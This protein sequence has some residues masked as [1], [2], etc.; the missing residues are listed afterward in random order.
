MLKTLKDLN[1]SAEELKEI[2]KLLAKKE[3]NPGI[4]GYKSMSEMTFKCS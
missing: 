3:K 2:A 4:K 1:P